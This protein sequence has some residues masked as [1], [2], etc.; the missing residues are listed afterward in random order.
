MSRICSC[1]NNIEMLQSEP[2][3]RTDFLKKRASLFSYI[4]PCP[5]L[6]RLCWWRAGTGSTGTRKTCQG[7]RRAQPEQTS[8]RWRPPVERIVVVQEKWKIVSLFHDKTKFQNEARRLQLCRPILATNLIG[9]FVL[10]LKVLRW[11][12]EQNVAHGRQHH[13]VTMKEET[14]KKE[15][16]I[17]GRRTAKKKKDYRIHENSL[18]SI[19]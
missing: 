17:S 18:A 4:L 3:T 12:L 9:I 6:R 1:E 7:L 10:G 13:H 11:P 19:N 14:T 16:K 8:S 15:T 5:Q 2:Y